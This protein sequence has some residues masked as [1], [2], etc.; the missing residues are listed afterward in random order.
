MCGGEFLILQSAAVSVRILTST[1]CGKEEMKTVRNDKI[2][3]KHYI[4]EA[5][6]YIARLNRPYK[7]AIYFDKSNTLL[8]AHRGLSG[9]RKENT[10]PAYTLAGER[11]YFGIET[12]VH[13]TADGKFVTIHDD[14]TGRVAE[15]NFPVEQT[16]FEKLRSLKLKDT[17]GKINGDLYIPTMEEYIDICKK[18][19]SAAVLE[20]KNHF[21][22][23]D[24]IEI[25][26]IIDGMGYLERTIFISFDLPNLITLRELYPDQPAQYLTCVFEGGLIEKLKKYNLDLD[27]YFRELTKERVKLLHDNGIKINCWTVNSY[28]AATA[29]AKWGVDYITTNILE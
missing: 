26:K 8:I 1:F 7:K 14:T 18:Y 16:K 28:K 19:N 12:D 27:I 13:R 3:F 4:K 17:N 22:K 24:I 11:G 15:A 9:L 25:T 29:L 6:H 23:E 5:I 10:I 21:E 20:L 2:P